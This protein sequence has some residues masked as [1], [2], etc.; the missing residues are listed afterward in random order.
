MLEKNYKTHCALNNI[1][2]LSFLLPSLHAGL[3]ESAQI[4]PDNF[5]VQEMVEKLLTDNEFSDQRSAKLDQ[6]D[7]LR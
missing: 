5:V 4:V 3:I 1:V 6:D 7:F 2:S